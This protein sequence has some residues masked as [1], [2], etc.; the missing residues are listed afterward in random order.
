M[1][2]SQSSKQK[3]ETPEHLSERA[4]WSR[5]CHDQ[6]Q[7]IEGVRREYERYKQAL[8]QANGRLMQLG[9]DPVKLE[10]PT[11]EPS[12]TASQPVEPL[13]EGTGATGRAAGDA[14]STQP[15]KA[16]LCRT[17]CFT[18][19]GIRSP[20]PGDKCIGCGVDWVDRFKDESEL[21]ATVPPSVGW[22]PMET[23]PKDGRRVLAWCSEWT[24][25]MSVQY[26][27]DYWSTEYGVLYKYQPTHWVPMPAPP[28]TTV[29]KSAAPAQPTALVMGDLFG[30]IGNAPELS[31]WGFTN[32]TL[33]PG[34]PPAVFFDSKEEFKE[35]PEA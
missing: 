27:G 4:S 10:Y 8:Y 34:R 24:G 11:V 15:P 25:P 9:L 30:T 26:Y 28:S 2:D 14:G 7:E 31:E 19:L 18:P 3:R 5:I 35:D 29:T 13:A 22:N 6:R 21:R 23:A 17:H 20:E 32:V 1:S 12:M 33:H 16:Q